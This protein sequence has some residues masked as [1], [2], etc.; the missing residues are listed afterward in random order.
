MFRTRL[1]K[2]S[3]LIT[4]FI[5]KNVAPLKTASEQQKNNYARLVEVVN[6]FESQI[7]AS[8]DPLVS[9]MNN[10]SKTSHVLKEVVDQEQGPIEV[11]N[12]KH[13]VMLL[14]FLAD[15]HVDQ[16]PISYLTSGVRLSTFDNISTTPTHT[17]ILIGS[18][19]KYLKTQLS[20]CNPLEY[21]AQ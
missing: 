11:S 12:R 18:R 20:T 5:Q 1:V 9:D 7:A 19:L 3:E 10:E 8:H 21:T 15:L 6:R 13:L 14:S 16:L 17:T 2:P 4:E